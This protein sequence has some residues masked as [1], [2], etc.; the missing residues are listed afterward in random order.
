VDNGP[1]AE[2]TPL[3]FRAEP[4]LRRLTLLHFV[5]RGTFPPFVALARNDRCAG[6]IQQ[7]LLTKGGP[8]WYNRKDGPVSNP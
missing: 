4:S 2:D 1:I 5:N 8:P 6:S 3:R 7:R